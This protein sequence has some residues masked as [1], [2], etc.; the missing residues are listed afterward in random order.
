MESS[1][2]GDKGHI[3]QPKKI[4]I[5]SN[6]TR[7][8]PDNYKLDDL[9]V[10]QALERH[11]AEVYI[12]DWRNRNIKPTEFDTL[13]LRSTWDIHKYPDE[14]LAW[15]EEGADRIV[16]G[17]DAV[18][19]NYN[20]EQYLT[21][22]RAAF[23]AQVVRSKFYST[24]R[25]GTPFE[26]ERDPA[27][28]I[29]DCSEEWGSG[30]LVLKPTVSAD[31]DDTYCFNVDDQQ[32]SL[33]AQA[34]L[35]ELLKAKQGVI[36][37]PM[38]EGISQGEYSLVFIGGV[39]THAVKKPGGF[40]NA[41]EM[42]RQGIDEHELGPMRSLA[43]KIIAYTIQNKG[44]LAY[45]RVDLVSETNGPVLLELEII[46]PNLQF[47]RIPETCYNRAERSG[48]KRKRE[49]GVCPT[50]EDLKAGNIKQRAVIDHFADAIL[51]SRSTR[52]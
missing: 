40:K 15:L 20:K 19:W 14:F 43:D 1:D 49:D 8:R 6:S 22:L 42:N 5:A 41:S 18:R 4:G 31:G 44:W 28:I 3:Q 36:V 25:H 32:Q 29:A 23:P 33:E 24:S 35:G 13:V 37:Q 21:D 2:A 45:A 50:L 11:G 17:V 47:V 26:A 51:H 10:Q 46:E 30:K 34:K 7:S 39:F 48:Q 27:R 16:N 12:F 38:L 9:L 52:K